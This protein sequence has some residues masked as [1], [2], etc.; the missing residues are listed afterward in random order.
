M[1]DTKIGAPRSRD[2][3]LCLEIADRE[4]RNDTHEKALAIYRIVLAQCPA[5]EQGW[6]DWPGAERNP[7]ASDYSRTIQ[8]ADREQQDGRFET[9]AALYRVVLARAP[10]YVEGQAKLARSLFC[11][12]RWDE[13]WRAFDIRFKL[14]DTPPAVNARSADGVPRDLPRIV[15]GPPPPRL[16]VLC[17]QGMGDTVQ[18][19][20]FLPRLMEAG[21]DLQVVI[22]QRLF[23]LLRTLD[24]APP[25][26]PG[27][28]PSSL[29]DVENWTTMMDLPLLLGLKE[30]DYLAREPYLRADPVRVARWRD[31]LATRQGGRTGPV[32]AFCWRG[33][34]EHK[35]DPSRS[36]KL[37][38]LAPLADIPDATLICLQHNATDE[39]IAASGFGDRIVRPGPDFDSGIDAF[40]DSAALLTLVDRLVCVDTSLAHVAGALHCR[41]E[42]MI[43]HDWAD[44]RWIDRADFNVW[45]PTMRIWRREK[46]GS[47]RDVAARIAQAVATVDTSKALP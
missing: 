34:P 18:F 27:E 5:Y 1:P 33:N 44:W 28:V 41:V 36:A 23:G 2:F 24:P 9:A 26:L 12:R 29:R 22:P 35:L 16:L 17:E 42:M 11:L 25:C 8:V 30:A 19:S 3:A 39:E 7:E 46:E 32:I 40:L 20:R 31:W 14:M 6:R 45:Y 15:E 13:A 47:Y 38:D 10:A 37:A 4:R 43:T 21:V